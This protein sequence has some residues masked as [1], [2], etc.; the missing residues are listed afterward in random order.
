[1]PL[2]MCKKLDLCDV[3]P[4]NITL[5]LANWT[6]KHALGVL[7]DV[8]I[9]DE[10]FYISIKFVIM[11]IEEDVYVPIILGRY[12][13]VVVGTVI[14]VKQGRLMFELRENRIEF[15]FPH[16]WDI[17][18]VLKSCCSLDMTFQDIKRGEP[19]K[20][21]EEKDKLHEKSN[22]KYELSHR[23]RKKK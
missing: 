10:C 21:E 6:V 9:R 19:W 4:T 7:E 16:L 20:K 3:K 14:Y 5:Q 13:M 22:P 11:D 17:I 12:F 15:V 18:N 2:T 8:H 23:R 1:M